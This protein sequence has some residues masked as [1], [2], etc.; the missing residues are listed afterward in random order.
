MLLLL[1]T[2][3]FFLALFTAAFISSLWST[4]STTNIKPTTKTVANQTLAVNVPSREETTKQSSTL[5]NCSRGNQTTCSSDYPTTSSETEK[6]EATC[7]ETKQ[8]VQAIIRQ[9]LRKQRKTRQ[10]VRSTSGGFTRI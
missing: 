1:F 9:H 3:L 10:H 4:L 7:P 8:H 6:N 5:L 2:L